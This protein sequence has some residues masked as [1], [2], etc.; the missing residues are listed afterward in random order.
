MAESKATSSLVACAVRVS[1]TLARLL[2]K[3]ANI[4]AAGASP[5]N[6]L[7][8][9]AGFKAGEIEAQ[10]GR[11]QQCL[12]EL[13]QTQE[14]ERQLHRALDQAKATIAQR[15][16]ELRTTRQAYAR[17]QASEKESYAA[18]ERQTTQIAEMRL[19]IDA[20]R[21]DLRQSVSTKGLD[22]HSAAALGVINDRL[23]C[24]EKAAA[25]ASIGDVPAVSATLAKQGRREMQALEGLL[26]RPTWRTRIV[27][28]L[29]RADA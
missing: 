21:E 27:L 12:E 3:C 28:W 11:A 10:R 24:G 4:E 2:R 8:T 26:V 15:D 13:A 25:L 20:Q 22:T 29:L 7:L 17:A 5:Q 18:L 6:A 1:P 19:Q 9:V 14:R 23:H 16:N